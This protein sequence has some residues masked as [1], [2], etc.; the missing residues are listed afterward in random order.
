MPNPAEWRDDLLNRLESRWGQWKVYDAYYEGDQVLAYITQRAREQY[1]SLF[2]DLRNNYM[3]LVV[4]SA[5][6]RLRVQGFRFGD[7]DADEDAWRIW[8]A[9]DL[10][11]KS[12][13]VHTESIKLGESY[14]LVQPNGDLP[15]ITC[16]HPSQVI[17]ATAPG[18]RETRLA[19]L[20]CWRDGNDVFAN[21]YLPD[22]VVK[23]A[24]YRNPT[25]I[26]GA[27][28]W[29]GAKWRTIEAVSNP[30]GVVPI[31][32]VPNNPSMLKGGRSDLA[33]GPLS[34]QDAINKETADMLFGSEY[35]ALRQRVI[36]G[37]DQPRDPVTG[38]PIPIDAKATAQE[39]SKSSLWLFP[40]K[41]G[42]AFEFSATDL[43]NFRNAIDGFT[44]DLAAQTRIPV[45]YFRP[46]A[47][48][49]ISAEALIGLDAGLV[50]K[51]DDKKEPMGGAHEEMMRLAFRA[52]DPEDPRAEAFD[53]ETIWR[54]TESRSQA[55]VVDAA[56][57]KQTLG[58][59]WEQI[60]E[61][62]GYS[63][64]QIDR[65]AAL[66][67]QEALIAQVN[68]EPPGGEQPPVA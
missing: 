5:A 54:N 62:I 67:E 20:K 3:A 6:E 52:V 47:I 66:R 43:S 38:N 17:V 50:S 24:M 37:I 65:M 12:N 33:G 13:M 53:A 4:D 19:A 8:Q 14:W 1:G 31:I 40:G 55:Q 36:L 9:N 25:I 46:T 64:Q 30:L 23:Y 48:S 59:P 56:T 44:G 63:P 51:T 10:D 58:V 39:A 28:D 57:K 26:D 68:T 16:E 35:T 18:D 41:D 2:R 42:K 34:L 15:R 60:M 11:S 7:Q 29:R 22:R 45:Y 49:N 32:A 61:D 21:V 27:R